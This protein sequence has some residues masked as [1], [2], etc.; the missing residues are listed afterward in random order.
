MAH[1][2]G[3]HKDG[4]V[5][6]YEVLRTLFFCGSSLSVWPLAVFPQRDLLYVAVPSVGGSQP[7][8]EPGLHT[9]Q[10]CLWQAQSTR[11]LGFL[12]AHL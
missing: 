5:D 11:E 3:E 7:L 4:F 1:R 9:R 6:S 8:T 2:I 12:R 10:P